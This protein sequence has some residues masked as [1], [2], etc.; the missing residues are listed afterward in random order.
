MSEDRNA[1]QATSPERDPL[2]ELVE[3]TTALATMTQVLVDDI[4]GRAYIALHD[5]FPTKQQARAL[6]TQAHALLADLHALDD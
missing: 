3:M 6:I 2:L 4:D 1:Y 5:L